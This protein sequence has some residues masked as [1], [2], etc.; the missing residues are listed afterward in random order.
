MSLQLPHAFRG[1]MEDFKLK[2][3]KSVIL[4]AFIKFIR[5]YSTIAFIQF[6]N[7]FKPKNID[8]LKITQF[9]IIRK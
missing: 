5:I 8:Y 7:K 2:F 1:C 6:K 3:F 9:K 4:I